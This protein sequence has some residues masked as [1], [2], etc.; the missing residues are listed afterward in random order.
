MSSLL[1]G[2]SLRLPTPESED[3]E[4]AEEYARDAREVRAAARR[5][6]FNFGGWVDND[7]SGNYDPDQEG[8]AI[9]PTNVR[10][11]TIGEAA[12]RR[13]NSGES[14]RTR[15]RQ[16]ALSARQQGIGFD[17][18]LKPKL[19]E[20]LVLCRSIPDNWP[21]EHGWNV[22]TDEGVAFNSDDETSYNLRR[23]RRKLNAVE[24]ADE[25]EIVD[26]TGHPLARG[27]KGCRQL[28][29]RCPLLEPGATYPCDTCL[30]EDVDCE[31]NVEPA[32]KQ[33]CERCKQRRRHCTYN[34][35]GEDHSKPCLECAKEGFRCFAGPKHD[36]TRVRIAADG[37]PAIV[38][39]PK[40][41]K[42]KR[43]ITGSSAPETGRYMKCVG[44]RRAKRK[45]TLRKRKPEPPCKYCLDE[46]ME[47][48]LEAEPKVIEAPTP[49]PQRP[50]SHV[51]QHFQP[52]I[53]ADT[54]TT[55]FAPP[56][57][58]R[59]ST[60]IAH[61][62]YFNQRAPKECHWCAFPLYGL[63]GGGTKNPLVSMWADGR[64]CTEVSGG[65][66]AAGAPKPTNMCSDCTMSRLMVCAC[67]N[68]VLTLIRESDLVVA[69]K[70][71]KLLDKWD[72]KS[73]M[74]ALKETQAKTEARRQQ[75]ER[76]C[77]LCPGLARYECQTKPDMPVE[78][79]TEE[80]RRILP[81]TGCGLR[82]CEACASAFNAHKGNMDRLV[83]G[84]PKMIEG[85]NAQKY[86]PR[87]LRADYDFFGKDS[88]M[89][90]QCRTGWE[91][92]V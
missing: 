82:L 71:K 10:K 35:E 84:L 56:N 75:I 39:V 72:V 81:K 36:P 34:D 86:W 16:S 23:K 92:G 50:S 64:G 11:R 42:I 28:G 62:I 44:C 65:H 63:M 19:L 79:M 83:Q 25:D 18:V 89:V 60:K 33:T 76:W 9:Q 55:T 80:R 40:T 58:V 3:S 5:A 22:F 14:G 8:R 24:P 41:P 67:P 6:I 59:I 78:R 85:K 32:Q 45:C 91:G 17:V 77:S 1:G 73:T 43:T 49:Q 54:S 61:P 90:K 68:H 29:E 38:P 7:E 47:C 87:G 48:L 46:K 15:T 4:D 30:E 20:A 12:P 57:L 26:L 74:W 51:Q 37:T 21:P 53:S 27:C 52:I 70:G 2:I 31:L 69:K 66:V 13:T 88:F